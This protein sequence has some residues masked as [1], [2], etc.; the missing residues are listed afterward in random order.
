MLLK[1]KTAV[2][3]GV[4]NRFGKAAAYLFA[5]EGARIVLVARKPD[6]VKPIAEEITSNGGR[7]GYMIFNATDR[8]EVEEGMEKIFRDY[9]SIDILFNN[10]GGSYTKKQK[11]EEMDDVF[12][13]DVLRNNLR[14]AF[15]MSKSAIK[16]M[17]SNGGSIIN[18]SAAGKTLL[19][20]NS[21]Y[22]AA[23]GGII[24]LTRNLAREL[25]DYNIRVNCVRPGVVRNDYNAENLKNQPRN[26]KRKGNSE[27][28]AHA[29]LYFASDNSSWVTGQTLVV[30]GGEELFLPIE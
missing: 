12:W 18:V 7:A 29:A 3:S 28:V 13:E 2:I 10:A 22:A 19:D 1:E 6:L 14:S 20:G 11:L 24:G 25:R 27:D 4:G 30:D 5:N 16:Y 17:K 9:G 26:V 8:K 21:A 15:L 23:K